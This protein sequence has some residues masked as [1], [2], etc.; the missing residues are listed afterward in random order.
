MK[1]FALLLLLAL[2]VAARADDTTRHAKAKELIALLRVDRTVAQISGSV[3]TQTS[4][5]IRRVVGATPTPDQQAKGEAFQKKVNDLLGQQITWPTMEPA[6]IDLYA[7]TFSDEELDGLV[8]FYKS[9]AGKAL[10]ERGPALSTDAQKIPQQ[11]L[12]DLQPQLNQLVQDF[13]RDAAPK[14]ATPPPTL[15]PKP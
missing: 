5:I 7:R 11:K 2:P 13:A 3:N 14:S 6:Y 8:A 1:R 9:P 10:V 12:I 4:A 15:N